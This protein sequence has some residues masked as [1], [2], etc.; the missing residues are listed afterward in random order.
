MPNEIEPGRYRFADINKAILR[1]TGP[2]GGLIVIEKRA[3][4]GR[5]QDFFDLH[6]V[7]LY[8]SDGIDGAW[9]FDPLPAKYAPLGVEFANIMSRAVP[10]RF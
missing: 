9:Q 4:A 5:E 7:S 10:S 3:I 8:L 1:R 6:F 2:N